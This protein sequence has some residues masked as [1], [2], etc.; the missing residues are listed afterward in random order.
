MFNVALEDMI[1]T[2]P[3]EIFVT[4]IYFRG[5]KTSST[6]LYPEPIKSNRQSLTYFS[7]IYFN[8]ILTRTE[9]LPRNIFS[10]QK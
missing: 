6:G 2:L 8:I 7:A 9:G 3:L 5:L 1:A 10:R 4:K